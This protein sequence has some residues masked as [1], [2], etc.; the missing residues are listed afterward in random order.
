MS[1]L[2]VS[3]NHHHPDPAGRISASKQFGAIGVLTL[4]G[5]E[6]QSTDP[7]DFDL[8]AHQCASIAEAMR[9]WKPEVG[10]V[11]VR[12]VQQVVAS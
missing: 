3:T 7:V 12:P 1:G 5:C 4:G 11:E 2:T 10:S 9:A 6:I 8:L